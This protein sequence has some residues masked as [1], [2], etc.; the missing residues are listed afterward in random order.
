M[1]VVI[2]LFFMV[3]HVMSV[4]VSTYLLL[5]EKRYCEQCKWWSDIG[6]LSLFVISLIPFLGTMTSIIGCADYTRNIVRELD[7]RN[8]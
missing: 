2:I 1:I 6:A 4:C 8:I 5:L 7:K 3:I